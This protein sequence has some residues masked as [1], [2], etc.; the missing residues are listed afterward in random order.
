M[1][2][3]TCTRLTLFI[4]VKTFSNL[5]ERKEQRKKK[6]QQQGVSTTHEVHLRMSHKPYMLDCELSGHI[7][8]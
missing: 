8:G 7:A 6:K 4:T 1:Q 5:K 3:P 2:P